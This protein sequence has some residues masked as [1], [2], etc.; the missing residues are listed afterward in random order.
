[1]KAIISNIAVL[2]TCHNRKDNTIKCLHNLFLQQGLETTYVLEVFLVDDGSTDGTANQVKAQFP[3]VNIINGNGTLYW[4]RGMHLAWK[5]A[6]QTKDFDYYLWLND[7]TNL[8]PDAIAEMLHCATITNNRAIVCG[9]ICSAKTGTFTYGGRTKD[10]KE[11]I[12]DGEI[13]KCHNINGNCVLISKTVCDTTG[14]LDPI[15]PHAIGDYDYGLRAIKDGFEIVTTRIFIG[16]CERNTSLPAWCYSSVSIDKRIKALYSP[17]GN[18]HPYYFFIFEKRHLGLFTAFK[19][20]F[21]IH[22]RT[23]IPQL[24]R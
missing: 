5:T 2:I 23:L 21:S 13:Q 8:K 24:W 20:Y 17:L 16:Y 6:K 10:D 1:M 18:S 19:H 22:L 7:D 11:V 3:Q 14:F 4:N 15:F 12:P 9:A